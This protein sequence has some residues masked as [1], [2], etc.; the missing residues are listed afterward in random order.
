MPL[1]KDDAYSKD[2]SLT[3]TTKAY[4]KVN[5]Y[6]E[7][8][9]LADNGYHLLNTV[10]QPLD[11]C[12]SV[13]LEQ[14]RCSRGTKGSQCSDSTYCTEHK[15]IYSGQVQGQDPFGE[16]D[17]CIKALRAFET[18]LESCCKGQGN[19]QR[20]QNA[21][22]YQQNTCFKITV[23]KSI[24]VAGGMAGGSVDA[25]AVLRLLNHIHSGVFTEEELEQIASGIGADVP[26]SIRCQL[27]AGSR[28]G[29]VIHQLPAPEKSHKWLIVLNEN[30][31][32]TP[33]VFS[34]Y[35]QKHLK[36]QGQLQLSEL[37]KCNVSRE[38]NELAELVQMAE[39]GCQLQEIAEKLRKV[40]DDPKE[41]AK[42]MCNDL[43]STALELEPSLKA[44]F[45]LAKPYAYKVMV[46]GSGP[47][48]AIL[49][50]EEL[51]DTLAEQLQELDCVKQVVFTQTL[52]SAD[53]SVVSS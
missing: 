7:V 26:Y 2:F 44:I 9:G 38:T 50:K 12:D 16:K 20:L 37:K 28:Y 49:L 5:L 51:A 33:A 25:G 34:A 29:D 18:A 13:S 4:A 31:L 30:Q 36:T 6:L 21:L 27:C 32:S 42:H 3:Y 45:D 39:S 8:V 10:F 14:S 46:S 41:L 19:C 47:T 17:L 53:M 23:R 43:Q 40:Y 48:C 22:E 15:V 1:A 24:P 35:D 11:I 52:A